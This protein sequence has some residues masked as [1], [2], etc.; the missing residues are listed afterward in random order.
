MRGF[1][2]VALLALVKACATEDPV[3][4]AT[5]VRP[6][7]NAKCVGCHGG[8]KQAGGLGLVFREN[9]MSSIVPGSP[10]RSELIRRVRHDDP[11]LRMPFEGAPLEEDEIDIL[12]R[13]IE[14]GAEWEAH[15]AYQPPAVSPPTEAIPPGGNEIDAY[16]LS[17]LRTAADSPFAPERKLAPASPP[18]RL[19]RR[20]AL[21]ITGLPPS[22]EEMEEWL[23]DPSEEAYGAFVDRYLAS[24]RYG[25]HRA[26]I[27]LDLARY[28]DSRGYERDRPRTIWPY[29]DWVIR[30]YNED[31]PFDQFTIEQLAGDLLPDPT[32]EQ[33]I[34][35]AFHRNTPSNGEGGTDNEEYR[36]VSVLDRVNTTWEVWQG[37]T[38][39]CVQCHS[40]P[41]DPIRHEEFY[42]SYAYFNNTADHDHVWERPL[43]SIPR[44]DLQAKVDSLRTWVSEHGSPREVAHWRRFLDTR[45][46]MIRPYHFQ[47]IVGGVFT[48]RADEDF[49]VLRDGNSFALPERDLGEIRALHLRT[50]THRPATVEWRLDAADG[51]LL[52]STELER[53]WDQVTVVPLPEIEGMHR[54]FLRVSGEG[55]DK[56]ISVYSIYPERALPGAGRPE[57]ARLVAYVEQLAR[58]RDSLNV[59]VLSENPPEL[60]RTTRVFERGNWLVHGQEVSGNVPAVLPPIDSTGDRLAFARWLA[61]G[62]NPLTA[63]V[64]VNRIWAG[65]FGRGLVT[66][67]G[68]FGSQCALPTNFELL[69][70]LA[71]HFSD[72]LEWSVKELIRTIVRSR[73]YRQSATASPED[74]ERDPYNDWLARGPAGRLT[75]EQLR[76]QMLAVS[77]LLSDKMYGPGV[78]PPQPAGLWD[79]IPYSDLEWET[80]QGEDRYR[81]AVYTYLRRSVLYP[82]M[83]TFDG[84]SREVCLSQRIPTNTPLQALA[85][86]NDPAFVEG[87]RRVSEELEARYDDPRRAIDALYPRLLFRP[88]SEAELDDLRALYEESLVTYGGDRREAMFVLVNVLFNVDEFLTKS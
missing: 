55:D 58:E 4:F 43:V 7:F 47:E 84:S 74:R 15:W 70:Y 9:A 39:A 64:T 8:V 86:L 22:P 5:D 41:Y 68:D 82:G 78:M 71:V 80:S 73:T 52:A 26:A 14:Q 31:M 49:L 36:V 29:R 13:W 2:L 34:A 38:M 19:L 67:L 77:G 85:T 35:T 75:A 48:D 57:H 81:R 60:S 33:L 61:S 25:E 40:H 50:N 56:L 51:P 20:L 30:A 21:D 54:I 79:H 24:P 59:P 3:S 16:V 6:I 44:Q 37:T 1:L 62:E 23:A 87:M 83:T 10:G 76:D 69:D 66:T 53:G 17:A 46:P 42:A 12:E 88:A 11:E 65:F 72:E 27:W 45:E 32:R 63:R 28:A 18:H